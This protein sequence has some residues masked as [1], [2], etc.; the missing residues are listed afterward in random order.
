MTPHG[1]WTGEF[2][3]VVVERLA[4]VLGCLPAEQRREAW[5]LQI[6]RGRDARCLQ[7]GRGEIDI[8]DQ[9]VVHRPGLRDTRPTNDERR[10]ER[11][12]ENPAFVEPA[13][14]TQEETLVGRVHDDGVVGQSFVVEEL[15]ESADALVDRFDASEVVMQVTLITPLDQVPA[16]RVLFSKRF[17]PR[18][19]I[20]VPLGPLFRIQLGGRGEL[21][22]ERREGLGKR[23][24]LLAF[25]FATAGIVVEQRVRFRID[26]VAVVAEVSQ[27]G[28]PFAVRRLVLAHQHE[29]LGFIAAFKPFHG[30]VGDDVGDVALMFH[31]LAVA[32]HRRVVVHT[33]ARQDV[34]VI[35]TGRFA[36][37]MPLPDDRRL[38]PGAA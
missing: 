36:H 15:Q 30:Q 10:A 13:M 32:D 4:P 5:T 38:V 27:G 31:I 12:L 2:V 8:A 29:R 9:V 17:V 21:R 14:F 35:E 34:P 18:A 19:I 26:A 37:Q 20:G 23:H 25:R 11:F 16:L 1:V 28:R 7:E 24:V 22:V 33:L 6:G 3:I